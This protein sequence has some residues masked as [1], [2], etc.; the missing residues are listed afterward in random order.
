MGTTTSTLAAA[1][2]FLSWT[3]LVF[4]RLN[5]RFEGGSAQ[6]IL[7]WAIE[8]FGTGLSIGTSFGGSGLVLLDLALQLQPDIDIFYIDTGFFFPETQELIERVQQ[9]YQRSLRRIATTLTVERQAA[10]YGPQLYHRNPDLCCHLRKVEPLRE[11]LFNT[12]AWASA[13]RR[14]QSATRTQTPAI[15]WN[16]RHNLVK[17]APLINWTE[18]EIWEYIDTHHL[19][20]NELHDRN[21]PSIGCWPCTR[22]VKPGED[23]RR[24]AL[25]R[26][27]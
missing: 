18:A 3:Y 2:G 13:L 10:Q 12:T 26:Y 27:G 22:A 19:P 14:D 1:P 25:G 17:L 7:E 4:S 8:T 23:L 5:A 24:G 16:E 9:H 15:T 6:S 20:Y 11:A 21:Y